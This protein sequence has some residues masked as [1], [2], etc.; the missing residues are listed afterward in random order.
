MSVHLGRTAFL[1]TIAFLLVLSPLV[2]T[3]LVQA[4]S[5]ACTINQLTPSFPSNINPGQQFQ[6]TTTLGISCY[7][8]RTYYTGR[9]D[10]VDKSSH[11][12]LS[13]NYL[14]IGFKPTYSSTIT[15]NA[16]APN[17]NGPWNLALNLYIFEEAS[18]VQSSI[19]HPLQVT[20][21]SAPSNAPAAATTSQ[22]AQPTAQSNATVPFEATT[23]APTENQTALAT[24]GSG[25]NIWPY[26]IAAMIAVIILAAL[27]I[28]T[29][30]KHKKSGSQT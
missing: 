25:M 27:V 1:A 3:S 24:G 21:G 9:L 18:M 8:W 14:N 29:D 11:M 12:V 17:T 10:L 5:A 2:S 16:T 22:A 23:F 13:S 4:Q 19:N 30:Q 7:Q 6:V 28:F 26:A 15:N 20:V